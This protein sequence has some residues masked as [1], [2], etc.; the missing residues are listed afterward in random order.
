MDNRREHEKRIGKFY[1]NEEIIRDSPEAIV[2]LF[3]MIKFVPIRVE[4]LYHRRSIEYLGYSDK[5][6]KVTPGCIPYDYEINM[7]MTAMEGDDDAIPE[8]EMIEISRLDNNL[9]PISTFV[10]VRERTAETNAKNQTD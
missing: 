3:H 8:I 4:S 9:K 1:I 10:L 5:F 7:I 2:Q 6:E